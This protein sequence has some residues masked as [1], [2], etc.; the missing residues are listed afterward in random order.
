[1]NGLSDQHRAM[2]SSAGIAPALL[3][4]HCRSASTVSD[5]DGLGFHPTPG[6]VFTWTRINGQR[7]RQYR[8][9]AP[10]GKAKYV[11]AAGSGS[12]LLI[13]RGHHGLVSD[14]AVPLLLVEGTKQHL[15]AASVGIGKP[16]A[17]AGLTGCWGWRSKGR[18]NDDIQAVPLEGRDV[19]IG[20]DADLSQ[21]PNVLAAAWTLRDY[22]TDAGAGSVRFLAIPGAE[23][24]GLDD[25]LAASSDP[26][27]VLTA[28][29]SNAGPHPTGSTPEI[30]KLAESRY[31]GSAADM[32]LR[33]QALVTRRNSLLVASDDQKVY[34]AARGASIADEFTEGFVLSQLGSTIPATS[35][36]INATRGAFKFMEATAQHDPERRADLHLRVAATTSGHLVVDLGQP[37]NS[38]CVVVTPGGW[39]VAARPPEN[40]RFRRTAYTRPLPTPQTG[41]NLH[42]FQDLLGWD[43]EL[44]PLLRGWLAAA[45]HHQIPRPVLGFVGHAGSGK[46]TSARLAAMLVDP[47]GPQPGDFGSGFK[48]PADA[49]SLALASFIPKWDNVGVKITA[50]QSDWFARMVTGTSDSSRRLYTN[51]EV[52]TAAFRRTGI[53]TAVNLP[54]FATDALDRVIPLQ[55]TGFDD[56]KQRHTEAKLEHAFRNLWPRLLGAVLDDLVAS[57]ANVPDVSR[58]TIRRP[59]MA[60]YFNVLRA[61]E[62]RLADAFVESRRTL[63]EEA[64]EGDEVVTAVVE[65]LAQQDGR[66][67]E[68]TATQALESATR[69]LGARVA[70]MPWW[71]PD[72]TR[73]GRFIEGN[74]NK[75]KALGLRHKRV[76]KMSR[77][78]RYWLES[79]LAPHD[80]GH[81]AGE[82]TRRNP[83][84]QP[85]SAG[86]PLPC[87]AGEDDAEAG[88]DDADRATA[89]S[90]TGVGPR[91]TNADNDANYTNYTESEEDRDLGLVAS[92]SPSDNDGDFT[93]PHRH[94]RYGVIGT[95]AGCVESPSNADTSGRLPSP[96]TVIGVDF[97]THDADQLHEHD[98]RL[99]NT[100]GEG[101]IRVL[102]WCANDGAEGTT[103]DPEVMRRVLTTPNTTLVWFNGARFDIPAAYRYLGVDVA[104]KSVDVADLYRAVRPR[105]SKDDSH[106][107][108]TISRQLIAE[109]KNDIGDLVDQY[110]GWGAIPVND[111]E[112]RAYCQQDARLTLRIHE[113]LIADIGEYAVIQNVATR[114]TAH[115]NTRG[116]AVDAQAARKAVDEA[117]EELRIIRGQLAELG[118]PD[119]NSP[120]AT[121]GAQQFLADHAPDDWPRTLSG[122]YSLARETLQTAINHPDP[123]LAVFARLSCRAIEVGQRF[124]QQVLQ[125]MKDDG[126]IYPKMSDDAVNGRWTAKDPNLLGVGKRSEK[127]LHERDLVVADP[128]TVFIGCDLSAID[129]RAVAG[130][131]GDTGYLDAL[132]PGRDLHGEVAQQL[133][134]TRDR[135]KA[136]NHGSNYGLQ[137]GSLARQLECTLESAQHILDRMDISYPQVTA[138]KS[139][140]R[141]QARA[142]RTLDNG[143]GRRI[144]A[145]QRSVF[146]EAPARV[147]ASCARDLLVCSLTRDLELIRHLAF[148]V[149]DEVVLQVPPDQVGMWQHRLLAAMTWTWESPSGLEVPILAELA[150]GHGTRW[151]DIYKTP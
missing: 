28:L 57:L 110:G 54:N 67:F 66:R 56:G 88:A 63:L 78:E 15:A 53:F 12:A 70:D 59:R 145:G 65:W 50:E 43:D 130:L 142:G 13:P 140:I 84:T 150:P 125:H 5:L 16:L 17:I 11:Q 92:K 147:A 7:F 33:I 93:Q 23:K 21:N 103:S 38:N 58:E 46:T 138:W 45:F 127:L 71:P 115:V 18:P 72:A 109:S 100:H 136:V 99:M 76:N 146:T 143:F 36:A 133:G 19:Y 4:E 98:P 31:R 29:L 47:P 134:I 135:A 123:A 121:S 39:Q 34:A 26:A 106:T 24:Q 117:N 151:S 89:S 2:L 35:K 141:A 95:P 132:L 104:S 111:P 96:G 20:F 37:G 32:S 3:A 101:F 102:G 144:L 82:G 81:D 41:G 77:I 49:T 62:P 1:M 149:H 91:K 69:T 114:I 83:Q 27:G 60:D 74:T 124:A 131:S 22:L 48:A 129:N 139:A 122:R 126:R 40:I 94:Q 14:P 90:T 137:A 116:L 75:L 112:Y 119:T 120:W 10:N 64:A 118:L 73:W 30:T 52:A 8:P 86:Q 79:P 25:V 108:N 51:H 107:L 105:L 128:G 42:A 44:W 87:R 80:A 9:D 148:T 6:I 55:L 97:E 61:V 68:G 85:G 113:R